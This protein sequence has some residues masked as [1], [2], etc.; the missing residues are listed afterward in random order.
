MHGTLPFETEEG[1]R[2]REVALFAVVHV[3]EMV[4]DLEKS[5]DAGWSVS[6]VGRRRGPGSSIASDK[7]GFRV[8]RFVWS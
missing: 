6:D 3:E 5:Y 8:A 1:K 4:R 7:G 2:E